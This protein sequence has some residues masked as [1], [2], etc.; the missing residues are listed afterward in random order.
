MA[1]SPEFLFQTFLAGL[2]VS[3]STRGL[4]LILI[5]F[6]LCILGILIRTRAFPHLALILIL[7]VFVLNLHVFVIF[8]LD[9]SA[10]NLVSMSG[11]GGP[12]ADQALVVF[13]KAVYNAGILLVPGLIYLVSLAFIGQAPPQ[14]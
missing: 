12:L 13:A 10:S 3:F 8:P 9:V 14:D 2:T 7:L 6:V 4:L 1:I 5:T 11:R